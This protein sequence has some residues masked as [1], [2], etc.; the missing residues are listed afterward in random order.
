M[1][2]LTTNY[3]CVGFMGSLGCQ[4]FAGGF[5]SSKFT[6]G[7]LPRSLERRYSDVSIMNI[8]IL[9]NRRYIANTADSAQEQYS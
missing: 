9:P 7:L 4:L 8:D 3:S 5:A 6:C 1:G 2:L